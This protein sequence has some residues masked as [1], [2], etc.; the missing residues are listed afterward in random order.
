[1][2]A[3][4]RSRCSGARSAQPLATLGRVAGAARCSGVLAAIGAHLVQHWGVAASSRG[5]IADPRIDP[6]LF[7]VSVRRCWRSCRPRPLVAPRASW[8]P[9]RRSPATA[10]W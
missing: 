6:D 5:P 8:R 4:S 10:A 2:G 9:A 7:T 3:D 1:M